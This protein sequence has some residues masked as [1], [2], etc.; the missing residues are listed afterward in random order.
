MAKKEKGGDKIDTNAWMV[1]FSDLLTLLLTFFVMLLTMSSMDQQKFKRGFKLFTAGIGPMGMGTK[2]PVIS[3]LAIIEPLDLQVK[4]YLSDESLPHITEDDDMEAVQAGI[5]KKGLSDDVKVNFAKKGL[6]LS[7]SEDI[8]FQ[9]G[10]ADINP[11]SFPIL[12]KISVI[13]KHT[14]FLVR[15]EGH[16]DNIPIHSPDY[17]SNWELSVARAVNTL[18]K[19]IAFGDIPPER[20]SA[21]GYADTKPLYPN[22]TQNRREKN[23]RVELVLYNP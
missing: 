2:G 22:N 7:F 4:R 21:V 1:T 13:I 6:V 11:A 17:P 8:L 16:T 12:K 15:V 18:N 3:K 10:T 9:P 23:R 19:I 5:K 14:N 20:F